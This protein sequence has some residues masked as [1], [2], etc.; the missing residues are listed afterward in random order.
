MCL[1]DKNPA[2][3]WTEGIKSTVRCH[4]NVRD[5]GKLPTLKIVLHRPVK[6]P[7]ISPLEI[8]S[9]PPAEAVSEQRHLCGH[10]SDPESLTY[11]KAGPRTHHRTL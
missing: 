10:C 5:P 11:V 8:H 3:T 1:T 2:K 4:L 7:V 6:M 9:F